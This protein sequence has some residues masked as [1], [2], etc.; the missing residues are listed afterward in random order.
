MYFRKIVTTLIIKNKWKWKRG[1]HYIIYDVYCDVTY[2]EYLH[3]RNRYYKNLR[4]LKYFK[5]IVFKHLFIK[6]K[7]MQQNNGD[8]SWKMFNSLQTWSLDTIFYM[9][10]NTEIERSKKN[11]IKLGKRGVS[12]IFDLSIFSHI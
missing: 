9:T 2:P 3:V 5:I 4:S 1:L 6:L 8:W 12:Y 10:N 7:K 11:P